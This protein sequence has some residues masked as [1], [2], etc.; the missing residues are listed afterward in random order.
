LGLGS[1]RAASSTRRTTIASSAS[2]A[3]HDAALVR[4]RCSSYV[5]G[6]Y[7]AGIALARG[8]EI[9]L[10]AAGSLTTVRFEPNVRHPVR[11]V[12]V[13]VRRYGTGVAVALVLLAPSAP[14]LVGSTGRVHLASATTVPTGQDWLGE[15]NMYRVASGLPTVTNEPAWDAGILDHLKYLADTPQSYRTGQYASA[16]TENPA[17]P[18]YTAAGAREGASS[19]LG[20]GSSPVSAIDTWL[21]CPFHAVGILRPTLGQ[22]AFA[23]GYGGAGLDVIS[24]LGQQPAV[25]FPVLFPGNGMTTDLS[26]FCGGEVPSPLQTCG[27][28]NPA[29]LPLIAL[30]TG[31]PSARLTASLQGPAGQSMTSGSD[32]LCTVDANTYT[33]TDTIYGPTGAAILAGDNAVFLIPRS[34]LGPG[35][36]HATISQPGQPDVSWSFNIEPPPSV[37][38]TGLFPAVVGRAYS[39][40]L[41]ASGGE[42][43]LVWSLQSG[44]LPAG[45]TLSTDGSIIGTPTA[46][47]TST[48]TFRVTDARGLTAKSPP[49]QLSVEQSWMSDQIFAAAF[50]GKAAKE[51][52]VLNGRSYPYTWGVVSGALPL[53]L[54]LS[55]AGVLSGT[56]H[57]MGSRTVTVKITDAGGQTIEVPL[58]VSVV[59]VSSLPRIYAYVAAATRSCSA[60]SHVTG[61]INVDIL[62]PYTLVISFSVGSG[63]HADTATS[64]V[65]ISRQSLTQYT[66]STQHFYRVG[67]SESVPLPKSSLVVRWTVGFDNGAFQLPPLSCPS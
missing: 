25:N 9:G 53:G 42:A 60:P 7:L 3:A 29:G 16:H 57:T 63:L 5:K 44:R 24:G 6:G 17:S 62:G 37:V 34:A 35:T 38:T 61:L 20:G 41:A 26:S 33:S 40:A 36:Y 66:F 43:P 4:P 45:L 1:A 54:A 65:Q 64:K 15:V 21:T 32:N 31:P 51:Q 28:Q 14:A 10:L 30:L 49:V 55:P 2:N 52:L 22:V 12:Q 50:V 39:T 47:G 59:Q 48:A 27:W 23:S 58:T 19:D 46:P 11:R 13:K 56:A 18:Y 8:P 67:T